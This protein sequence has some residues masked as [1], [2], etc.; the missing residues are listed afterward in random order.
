MGE[1]NHHLEECHLCISEINDWKFALRNF[2]SYLTVFCFFFSFVLKRADLCN[3]ILRNTCRPRVL[4]LVALPTQLNILRLMFQVSWLYIKKTHFLKMQGFYIVTQN[5]L[6][7]LLEQESKQNTNYSAN[8][9]L[10][11]NALYLWAFHIFIIAAV[12]HG[13]IF[14]KPEFGVFACI[15]HC[16]NLNPEFSPL[17]KHLNFRGNQI[18][19]CRCW[20]IFGNIYITNHKS[21]KVGSRVNEQRS[22]CLT[23][24]LRHAGRKAAY[25]ITFPFIHFENFNWLVLLSQQ[26]RKVMGVEV[27][28]F[29]IKVKTSNAV[30]SWSKSHGD[31]AN[32]QKVKGCII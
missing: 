8:S 12:G 28:T 6:I 11:F 22:S 9:V 24:I 13:E 15:L 17:R 1:K 23:S 32:G 20:M 16:F 10:N 26:R 29:Q 19:E 5:S 31:T 3:R 4:S 21:G 14:S 18:L 2:D 30:G 7:Q 27:K 25:P